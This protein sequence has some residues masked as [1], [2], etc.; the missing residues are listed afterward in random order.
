ML[1]RSTP[2]D[3][4]TLGDGG[5]AEDARLVGPSDV[6]VDGAGNVY[7]A[8]ACSFRLRVINTGGYITTL[9][10]T[11]AQGVEVDTTHST[12][13]N[14]PFTSVGPIAS[15]LM[16]VV[17]LVEGGVLRQ[18]EFYPWGAPQDA[19]SEILATGL[20]APPT[21]GGPSLGPVTDLACGREDY[22][23]YSA[24]G[25]VFE[26]S[27]ATGQRT[28]LVGTGGSILTCGASCPAT[29]PGTQ[30]YLE[31]LPRRHLNL[32]ALQAGL[33]QV[34]GVARTETGHLYVSVKDTWTHGAQPTEVHHVLHITPDGFVEL[35]G[36]N[37]LAFDGDDQHV[38]E[39]SPLTVGTVTL[40]RR[41]NLL[42]SGLGHRVRRL[43]V[44][45]V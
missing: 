10:G 26:V 7:I 36:G 5:L 44:A 6:A 38:A 16:G 41:G 13:V 19:T 29:E 25:H 18:V 30:S 8:D 9:A 40:D 1:F 3:P 12:A 2:P 45:P 33:G 35:E 20:T 11:G 28:L 21:A 32:Q 43:N 37:G 22:L 31:S 15:C 17:H 27:M 23:V 34:V 42:V 4:A 24:G 14:I 39:Q